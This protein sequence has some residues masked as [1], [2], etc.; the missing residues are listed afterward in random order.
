MGVLKDLRI[1]SAWAL[2]FNFGFVLLLLGEQMAKERI[3]VVGGSSKVAEAF[4]RMMRHEEQYEIAVVTSNAG[5]QNLYPELRFTILPDFYN[6]ELY[7][8]CIKPFIFEFKPDFV[9]NCAGYPA[10]LDCRGNT[11]ICRYLNAGLVAG[12]S[13]ACS[14]VDAH[15]VMF[16]S[17]R[18]FGA[19][20]GPHSEDSVPGGADCFGQT[21]LEAEEH[22]LQV[23]RHTIIRLTPVVGLSSFNHSDYVSNLLSSYSSSGTSYYDD[24]RLENPVFAEDAALLAC[25]LVMS[26]RTGVFNCGGK[27]WLTDFAAMMAICKMFSLDDSRVVA[28]SAPAQSN[29]CLLSLKMETEFFVSP[30]PFNNILTTMRY[31]QNLKTSL[32]STSFY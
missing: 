32:P 4:L 31:H 25:K 11:S 28:T 10:T 9:V 8:S 30:T 24:S 22:C 14:A 13:A 15:L 27:D 20:N 19:G 23:E 26:R 21:K 16:S 1:Q 6:P 2:G 7:D 5:V 18:I 12:L 3:L 29:N 17:S